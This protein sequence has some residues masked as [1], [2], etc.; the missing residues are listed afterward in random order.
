MSRL[1]LPKQISIEVVTWTSE[2]KDVPFTGSPLALEIRTFAR[3]RNDYHLGPFFSDPD[4]RVMITRALL[5]ASA[6][7][8]LD[9]G[10]MDYAPIDDCFALVEIVHWSADHVQRA[11]EARSDGLFSEHERTLWGSPE[12]VSRHVALLCESMV[13]AC[14]PWSRAAHPYGMG[15]LTGGVQI[16]IPRPPA[17]GYLLKS[18]G[19]YRG[20]ASMKILNAAFITLLVFNIVCS[21]RTPFVANGPSLQSNSSFAKSY[22]NAKI[23]AN[24]LNDAMLA[25]DYEKAANLTYQKLI[26]LIGGRAK[27]L[28][29]LKEGMSQTQSDVFRV[30]SIVSDEPTQIVEVGAD[31]YAVLPTTTKIKVAEGILIGQSSL[32]GVSND[33][34]EHWTF[35]S[36]GRGQ[37]QLR[38][39]FPAVADRLKIPEQK[40]P[41]LQRAP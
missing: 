18:K 27:Y 3:S 21:S 29:V 23:Q 41:V 11:I 17:A 10:L 1:H 26:Q 2:F 5:A 25:G 15:R 30:I 4:G 6:R 13:I 34:G 12:G 22:P 31:V 7:A 19:G 37:E 36:A 38:M 20:V 16:R 33:R 39:L 8:Q 9:W 28:S 40:Q 24:E 14:S 32:I 35:V